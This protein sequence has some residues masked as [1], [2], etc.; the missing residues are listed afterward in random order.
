MFRELTTEEEPQRV[1]RFARGDGK[2]KIQKS[3]DLEK[4]DTPLRHPD[5]EFVGDI[6]KHVM[7]HLRLSQAYET[8]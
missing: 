8:F 4:G 6:S 2:S 3:W 5:S 1:A 7:T